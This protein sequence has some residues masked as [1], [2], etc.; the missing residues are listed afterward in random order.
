MKRLISMLLLLAMLLSCLPVSV[1]ADD[2]AITE[3][4]EIVDAAPA[5]DADAEERPE[6]APLEEELPAEETPEE[7]SAE[8][9]M[10][11]VL[12]TDG[13]S[14][15]YF[16]A[17]TK[18]ELLIA[19]RKIPFT[20]G[21]RICDALKAAG[22]TLK[23]TSDGFLSAINGVAKGYTVLSAPSALGLLNEPEAGG[24]VCVTENKDTDGIGEGW[25]LLMEQMV[26]YLQETQD[27]RLA[28]K[29]AYDAAC[30][31]YCGVSDEDAKTYAQAIQKA[32][33]EYKTA[34][35]T[36]Y[37]VTFAGSFSGCT[38]TAESSYGK[39]FEAESDGTLRLPNGTYTFFIRNGN[40]SVSGTLTVKDKDQTLT[41]L[42][43]LPTEEWIDTASFALSKTSDYNSKFD[44]ER[45]TLTASEDGYT[46]SAAVPDTFSGNIYPYFCLSA[47]GKAAG[48]SIT[49]NYRNTAGETVSESI[50]TG[51][52]NKQLTKTLLRGASGNTVVFRVSVKAGS[53]AQN[54]ELTLKLN[55][56][57]TL[58]SLYLEG[59]SGTRPA[60]DKTFSGT[61]LSYTY[62]ILEEDTTVTVYPTAA[63]S[64]YTITVDGQTLDANGGA[65]VKVTDKTQNISVIVSQGDYETVYTL[66][67]EQGESTYAQFEMLDKGIEFHL[68]NENSEE[69]VSREEINDEGHV[70][71][72]YTVVSGQKYT[73][74]ATR[75]THYHAEK[76][77]TANAAAN[78]FEVSVPSGSDAPQLSDLLFGT[79]DRTKGNLP[80][81]YGDQTKFSAEQ[82]TYTVTIPDASSS[83]AVWA[84]PASGTSC[85]LLYQAIFDTRPGVQRKET[86]AVTS[87]RGTTIIDA[88]LKGNV[89]GNTLTFRASKEVTDTAS[90]G[91]GKITYSTDYVVTV[92]RSLTL[93]DLSVSC[94]GNPVTLNYDT[95][96]SG[97]KSSQTEYT[98]NVPGAAGFV[99]LTLGAHDGIV[100]GEDDSGYLLFVNGKAAA[101]GEVFQATLSGS[102]ETET[103]T[104]TVRSRADD[105]I[106]TD[107]TITVKKEAS[108]SAKITVTP[109]DATLYIYEKVS[110]IR[111][112]P[113]TNGK[114]SFSTGFTYIYSAT[115]S[116]YVGQSGAIQLLDG[117]LDFGSI[118]KNEDETETFVSGTKYDPGKTISLTLTKAPANSTIQTG[119]AAQWAD[120]RG[121]AYAE[122]GAMTGTANTNNGVTSAAIPFA[123]EE[124][125][126]YWAVNAGTGYSSNAVSN[127]ILVDGAVVVY[128]GTRILK[129]DKDTGAIMKEGTMA[130]KSS[131]AINNPTYA[132]GVILV[133]LSDGRIQAFN[134]DTLESLWLYTDPLGGQPDSPITVA[135]GYAYTGFWNSEVEEASFVCLSLT[136]EVPASKLEAKAETWRYVQKGG[137]YWAGAYACE[138]YVLIGTDD[139]EDG[140]SSDTAN[141]LLLDPKSGKLLDSMTGFTGDIRCSI[142]YDTAT[143]AFYFTSK[144]GYLYSVQV[145]KS[146]SSWK[147]GNKK[148]LK[149]GGMSTSTPVVHNG[150]AYIGVSGKGQFTPY[151]GHSITVVNLSNMSVAYRATTQGYP[152][153][154][155]LLTTAYEK[156]G[157]GYVYVYF[158]D[159]YTPGKLRVLR[160]K[161]GQTEAEYTSNEYAETTKYTTAYE[162]FTPV[163]PQMQYALCSPIVDENGTLYFKNDSGYLMA[164]GSMVESLSV[165]AK[166]TKMEYEANEKFDPAGLK[167]TATYANGV[168][169]DVTQLMKAADKA[170]TQADT[171]VTLVYGLGQTMYHN[172]ENADKTMKP[173]EETASKSISIDI[174][175]GDSTLT[176]TIGD[177]NW[178]YSAKTAKLIVS[179][180]FPSGANLIAAVY[181]ADGK[182]VGTK[183]LTA[184][185]ETELPTGAKIKL[186]LMDSDGKP[187]SASATVKGA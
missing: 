165:E 18:K 76:T 13:E 110:G 163:A 149:L 105:T 133:G 98:I 159:N 93:S 164:Y 185:G 22:I 104:V 4:E 29:N 73:Y 50:T 5:E 30:Q 25:Q 53:Y 118:R 176:G 142:C 95:D 19:P 38:I 87:G 169:R 72:F 39:Q 89:H 134:A 136:D 67:V 152:Q 119:M 173:G 117:K 48:A 121:T 60:A 94:G 179:G 183:I 167:V 83:F 43:A 90:G 70:V 124:G 125:T 36:L 10:A 63:F 172:V 97:F 11:A 140:Y 153:T 122:G 137:F 14:F 47:A 80:L 123:A 96:Q 42:P 107:Y 175:V 182:M 135:N 88:I 128:T 59:K 91:D 31:N 75:D 12:S 178:S 79:Q 27:V 157:N 57:P 26:Q 37:S 186:F 151:S 132:E 1:S 65:T 139:G 131:F 130:G 8:E 7:Q 180:S 148:Q 85:K 17:E 184:E 44:E 103:I 86:P 187:L 2:T 112:W 40:R 99:D 100:Y 49:A 52:K 170:L 82:L 102:M 46:Q 32:I 160:D 9:E 71:Y 81:T 144:G 51:M 156:S 155:G 113:D 101:P 154:S 145:Q 6:E 45:F 108:T 147:L 21:Q 129:I 78:I 62:K 171:S 111:L 141:L 56:Q 166:P 68:T 114:Y 120:F 150:R 146:G 74:S 69:L 41:D 58:S 3:A 116:G 28:A 54:E 168:K 34:Q 92:K 109:L 61:E 77:F 33:S 64:G 177:L 24:F 106:S 181:A 23:L 162:L 35:D 143:K 158:F 55:R 115:K 16:S 66:T 127:P 174:I 138:D 20:A 161:A 15:F 84:D 126:L